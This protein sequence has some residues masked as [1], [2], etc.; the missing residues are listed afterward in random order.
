[1]PVLKCQIKGTHKTI[2]DVLSHFIQSLSTEELR[3]SAVT[4]LLSG[5]FLEVTMAHM[6]NTGQDEVP[7]AVGLY[8]YILQH[9]DGR[10]ELSKKGMTDQLIQWT[11][12]WLSEV[13]DMVAE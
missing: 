1:M 4:V 6:A 3:Y 7:L 10:D 2:L 11:A 9:P 5:G 12:K 13:R 8:N